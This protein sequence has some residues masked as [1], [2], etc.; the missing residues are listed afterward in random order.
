MEMALIMFAR[1][2]LMII[3]LSLNLTTGKDASFVLWERGPR[4]YK[5]RRP[6]TCNR[7]SGDAR[8]SG[9]GCGRRERDRGRGRG[10]ERGRVRI[11][12]ERVQQVRSK[13]RNTP[14]FFC[15][16]FKT[17]KTGA[18]A[19]GIGTETGIETGIETG[20]GTESETESQAETVTERETGTGTET[21][22]EQGIA[23]ENGNVRGKEIVIKIGIPIPSMGL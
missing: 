16:P 2:N 18:G 15:S 3:N 6:C 8:P 10:R 23:S 12:R 4:R 11:R 20:R 22:I 9:A 13:R 5:D 17:W 19:A 7:A 1:I 21:E 14:H